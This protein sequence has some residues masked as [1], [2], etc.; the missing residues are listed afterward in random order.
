MTN[1]GISKNLEKPLV[2][3]PLS[4]ITQPLQIGNSGLIT[5]VLELETVSK[6]QTT[7]TPFLNDFT[8]FLTFNTG[9]DLKVLVLTSIS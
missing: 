2:N 7:N 8:F 9:I 1:F 3:L 6:S 4:E 5:P